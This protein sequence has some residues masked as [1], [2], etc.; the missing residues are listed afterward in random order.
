MDPAGVT[1]IVVVIKIL[2][3]GIALMLGFAVMTWVERKALARFTLRYGPN[4]ASKFGL[5]QP[6]ADMFKMFFKEEVIPSHAYCL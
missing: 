3:I 6:V 2:I 4:R 5:L 1:I